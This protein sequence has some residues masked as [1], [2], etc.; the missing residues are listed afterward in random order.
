MQEG[1]CDT[2]LTLEY[3]QFGFQ[4]R[5]TQQ[6]VPPEPTSGDLR[7]QPQTESMVMNILDESTAGKSR[8]GLKHRGIM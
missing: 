7:V 1:R 8:R 5:R 3:V 4:L 2:C 6:D